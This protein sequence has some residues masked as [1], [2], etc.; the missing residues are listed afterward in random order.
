[1]P[2]HGQDESMWWCTNAKFQRYIHLVRS[3]KCRIMYFFFF[4]SYPDISYNNSHLNTVRRMEACQ[5]SFSLSRSLAFSHSVIVWLV[6]WP[7]FYIWAF[8][9]LLFFYFLLC[10]FF[11]LQRHFLNTNGSSSSFSRRTGCGCSKSCKLW[12]W[13]EY[14]QF[15]E[16]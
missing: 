12:L 3:A 15:H 9:D 10:I 1:M 11:L 13:F 4:F 8:L 6:F 16:V 2:M 5:G 14:I 7:L